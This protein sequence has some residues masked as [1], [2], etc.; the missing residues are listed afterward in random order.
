MFF[1]H[2]LSRQRGFNL[3]EL[4]VTLAVLAILLAVALP[5]FRDL[6]RRSQVGSARNALS[7][8]LAYARTEAIT[9]GASVF[10]CPRTIDGSGCMNPD[11]GSSYAS[12]WLVYTY[13]PGTRVS[14]AAFARDSVGGILLRETTGLR[15]IS[16]QAT[17]GKAIGFDQQG[18]F[19]SYDGSATPHLSPSFLICSVAV[20]GGVGTSTTHVPG[21]SMVLAASGSVHHA[22]MV[23]GMPC[24]T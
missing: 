4:L 17:D 21:T 6:I 10:V 16:I 1:S 14:G 19:K 18:Q 12:G 7:A 2:R 9:R 23:S 20:A 13:K 11:M 5:T 15:G 3:V 22:V 8:D 24:S